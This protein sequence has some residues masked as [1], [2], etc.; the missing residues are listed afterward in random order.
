MRLK[1]LLIFFLI[2]GVGCSRPNPLKSDGILT[3]HNRVKILLKYMHLPEGIRDCEFILYDVN[4]GGSRLLPGPTDLDYQVVM[5][6]DRNFLDT[7]M[8]NLH[9][10]VGLDYTWLKSMKWLKRDYFP[11]SESNM[12]TNTHLQLTVF[13]E[14]GLV[15][16][17]YIQH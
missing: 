17:R 10:A 12:Y 2:S 13:R 3:P 15:Y 14:S 11:H 7:W 4:Q 5:K 1:P 16:L 8:T 9:P 6:V